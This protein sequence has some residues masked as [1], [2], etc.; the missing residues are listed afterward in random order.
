MKTIL[1][2]TAGIL[3]AIVVLIVAAVALVG[4][5][6]SKADEDLQKT[7]DRTG[8]RPTVPRDQERHEHARGHRPA[9]PARGPHEQQLDR[10][11]RA[12]NVTD[13]TYNVKGAHWAE[14]RLVSISLTNGR[15]D[16]KASIAG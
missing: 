12:H 3:L 4:A 14:P 6:A 13:L 16:A 9:R 8:D 10:S 1:K 2:I 11:R 7:D 5:G 15:V